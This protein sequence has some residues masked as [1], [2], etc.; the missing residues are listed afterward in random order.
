MEPTFTTGQVVF[1]FNYDSKQYFPA[2]VTAVSPG[3]DEITYTLEV[4]AG[5]GHA[6]RSEERTAAQDGILTFKEFTEV[7]RQESAES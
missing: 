2:V 3:T 6:L 7:I 5:T 4:Q 1:Y